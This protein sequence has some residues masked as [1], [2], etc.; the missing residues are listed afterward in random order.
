VIFRGSYFVLRAVIIFLAPGV[1]FLV[2]PLIV[3]II[4]LFDAQDRDRWRAIVNAVMNR[5]MRGI[6]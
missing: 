4:S 5:N 6:S 1:E 2:V 3:K